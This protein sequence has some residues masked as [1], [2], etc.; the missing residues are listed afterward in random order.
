MYT[1]FKTVAIIDLPGTEPI[2]TSGLQKNDKFR[3]KND[4]FSKSRKKIRVFSNNNPGECSKEDVYK[5][6]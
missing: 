5:V 1:L 2:P 6:S 4:D 3:R